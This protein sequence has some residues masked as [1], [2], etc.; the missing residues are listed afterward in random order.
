[1]PASYINGNWMD[2]FSQSREYIVT[3]GPLP[4]TIDAFW[5]MVWEFKVCQI[6]MITN[7]KEKGRVKCEKYWPFEGEQLKIGDLI[8][9]CEEVKLHAAFQVAQ[10][11]V[12]HRHTG[13]AHTVHHLWFQD[14][15][16]HGVPDT[17]EAVIDLLLTSREL[18]TRALASREQVAPI[19]VHCSAG[20][21]R[22]GVFVG[23][24]ILLQQAESFGQVDALG[25]LCHMR[26]ARGGC[27]QTPH[28]WLYM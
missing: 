8:L 16:D 19:A 24:D 10:L 2:G 23:C 28:Q 18:R 4:N 17:T 6:V 12:V 26:R 14:W 21:G 20:I 27:V 13:V 25:A 22:S 1:S 7:L 9:L 11:R 15:P 5:R 3:Q